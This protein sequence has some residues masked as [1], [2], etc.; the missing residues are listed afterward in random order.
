MSNEARVIIV[1]GLSGAGKTVTLRTLEDNGYYCVDNLPAT[2]IEEVI[3]LTFSSTGADKIAIGNDIRENEFLRDIDKLILKLRRTYN[4]TVLFLEA[5]T[6]IIVRRYKET[7]RPHPLSHRTGGDIYRAIA[8]EEGLLKPIRGEADLIIDTTNFSPHQLRQ[9]VATQFGDTTT[10]SM[11]LTLMSF[12]FKYGIPQH[13]DMLLDVRFLPNPH[14]VEGLRPMTGL[15][16][17]VKDFIFGN[18][19][20]NKFLVKIKDLLDFLLPLYMKEGKTSFTIGIGCTGGK[21]RAPAIT[22]KV[23]E[24]ARKYVQFIEI[25]HRD[26]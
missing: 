22:E 19:M 23:A 8:M 24:A 21:H 10:A 14:F 5:E 18:D 7:R 12:G 4:V 13:L 26:I 20:T 9:H 15:D 25:I 16:G 3:R 6:D 2:L 17:P 11:K 1:S